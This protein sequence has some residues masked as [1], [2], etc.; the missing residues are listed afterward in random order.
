M[1]DEKKNHSLSVKSEQVYCPYMDVAW[2]FLR[3]IDF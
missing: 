1:L 2:G 3:Y